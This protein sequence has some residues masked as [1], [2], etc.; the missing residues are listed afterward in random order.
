MNSLNKKSK[1]FIVILL[2]VIV[3]GMA[4]FAFL[5]FNKSVDYSN[6]YQIEISQDNFLEGTVS[7]TEQTAKDYFANNGIKIEEYATQTNT[8]KTTV[9]YKTSYNFAGKEEALKTA[10]ETALGENA[11]LIETEVKVYEAN[12]KTNEDVLML[13]IALAIALVVYFIY[14][15]IADKGA[16]AFTIILSAILSGIA[17]FSLMAITRIPAVPFVMVN[18]LISVIVSALITTTFVNR[19]KE[20]SKIAEYEKLSKIDIVNICLKNS[21]LRFVIIGSALLIASVAFMAFGGYSLFFG[22]QLLVATV[23]SCLTSVMGA[24]I[25]YTALKK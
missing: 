7:L 23:A 3:A 17:F 16:L 14:E 11:K 6:G 24:P 15:L 1:F 21:R 2:A 5:G 9:I 8:D 4:M 12:A 25:I 10:I 18:L 19:I 13:S 22:L 20:T